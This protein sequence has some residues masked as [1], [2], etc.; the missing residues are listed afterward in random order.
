MKKILLLI[1]CSSIVLAITG[2]NNS[3]ENNINSPSTIQVENKVETIYNDDEG[4]NLF[5]NKYNELYDP[6]ITSDMLSKMHIAGSD[7]DN[8]VTVANDKFEIN[9]YDNHELNGKYNMSVYVGYKTDIN[10]TID[11]YE[12]QFTKFIKLF[13]E[14]LSDEEINNYW[15]DLISSYHSSYEINDID[16]VTMADN[17]SI[18]YFKF[19]KDLKL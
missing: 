14:T 2:C 12:D 17:N 11:D 4:I 19:T 5:I 13:D 6:D 9:I 18:D 7:R 1:L 3:N 15:N 16:I 10:A 8:A